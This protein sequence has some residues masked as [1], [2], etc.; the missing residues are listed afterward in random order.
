MARPLDKVC[1]QCNA[2]D[3]IDETKGYCKKHKP[4]RRMRTESIGVESTSVVVNGWPI[5]MGHVNAC[6]DFE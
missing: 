6:G 1:N 5:V 2:Y 3:E 4:D